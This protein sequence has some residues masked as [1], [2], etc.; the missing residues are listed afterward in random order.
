MR[1]AGVSD[2]AIEEAARVC[3][4]LSVFNRLSDALDFEVSEGRALKINAQILLRAGYG[5]AVVPGARR[6]S[7]PEG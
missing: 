7:P 2:A 5:A 6:W 1:A 4:G 3:M